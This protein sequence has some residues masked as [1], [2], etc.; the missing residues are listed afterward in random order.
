MKMNELKAICSNFTKYQKV[1][2]DKRLEIAILIRENWVESMILSH[3]LIQDEFNKYEV[4]VVEFDEKNDRFNLTLKIIG[5]EYKLPNKSNIFNN[6]VYRKGD[7][8]IHIEIGEFDEDMNYTKALKRIFIKDI[9][10]IIAYSDDKVTNLKDRIIDYKDDIEHYKED[11]AGF[12]IKIDSAK[13]KLN[14]L[15]YIDD[16]VDRVYNEMVDKLEGGK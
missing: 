2:V 4:D 8:Y 13:N 1:M 6:Y 16:E 10:D 11:I 14:K 3:P 12:D 15:K 9:S 7:K 5:A